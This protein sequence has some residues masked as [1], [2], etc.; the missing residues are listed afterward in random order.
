MFVVSV[1]RATMSTRYP[2]LLLSRS[3]FKRVHLPTKPH[4]KLARPSSSD[5]SLPSNKRLALFPKHPQPKTAAEPLTLA[6][7][8]TASIFRSLLLG[9]FFSSSLLFTPGFALLKKIADSPSRVLNPDRNP[10]LRAVVKPFV[11]D[12]FCAG[13][14]RGEIRGRIEQIMGGGFSGVIL[15]YGKEIQIRK[16]GLGVVDGLHYEQRGFDQE[17][18]LWKEGN[19]ETLDMI[20][21]GDYLGIKY[22]ALISLESFI[23]LDEQIH[24]RWKIDNR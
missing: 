15:C 5:A 10:L 3:F 14:D 18:E 12:Q 21:D 22:D 23:D 1:L 7:L 8:P 13:T 20:G 19:L 11:Y 24:W 16:P 6:R 2:Q 9:A 17:L 4:P